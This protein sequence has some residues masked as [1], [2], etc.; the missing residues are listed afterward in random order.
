[1]HPFFTNHDLVDLISSLN[2]IVDLAVYPLL[3]KYLGA[4]TF[5]SEM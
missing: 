4:L 3:V 5:R 1:M 2:F